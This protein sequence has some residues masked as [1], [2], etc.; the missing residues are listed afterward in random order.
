MNKS[1]QRVC[2]CCGAFTSVRQP[3]PIKERFMEHV[4]K[5]D[6]CWNWNGAMISK[7]TY[8][9]FSYRTK[10]ML[11]HRASWLIHV[12]GINDGLFVLHTCDNPRCVN[13][14]HLFLGTQKENMRDA[15]KKGRL[16]GLHTGDKNLTSKI[17]QN[18]ANDIRRSRVEMKATYKELSQ[19]F[20]ICP[21]QVANIIKNRCW[22]GGATQL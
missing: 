6:G 4:D 20:S 16:A 19:M 8:G 15:V 3:R 10:R 21:T 12:G 17:N 22:L 11:A 18:I 9:S 7:G 1:I 5:T 14:E 2:P 13:P